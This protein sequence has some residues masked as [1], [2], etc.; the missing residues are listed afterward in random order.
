VQL[1]VPPETDEDLGFFVYGPKDTEEI[2]DWEGLQA[3]LR[4]SQRPC[5]RRPVPSTEPTPETT[6]PAT[7]SV[8]PK[9]G[10]QKKEPR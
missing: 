1:I 9:T 2:E 3:Q 4:N 8:E 7:E 5:D 6:A 10:S